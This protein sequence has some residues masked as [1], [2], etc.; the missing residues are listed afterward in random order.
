MSKAA[1]VNVV[2]FID[3]QKISAFQIRVLLLCGLVAMMD[4]FD[5]MALGYVAPVLS[6]AWH[7]RPGALRDVFA[8]GL[9]GMMVGALI[10]GPP[11]H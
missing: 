11:T 2:D 1:Q 10:F 4:G 9:F 5:V 3:Q 8:A 6:K 7:L